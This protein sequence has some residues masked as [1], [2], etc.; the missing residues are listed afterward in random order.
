MPNT[1]YSV[2]ILA[3]QPFFWEHPTFSEF[4]HKW[5]PADLGVTWSK[6]WSCFEVAQ[7]WQNTTTVDASHDIAYFL[8]CHWV[9]SKPFLGSFSSSRAGFE[10]DSQKIHMTKREYYEK[11]GCLSEAS[12]V[13]VDGS[14][15]RCE[16]PKVEV[17][18]DRYTAGRAAWI[19]AL[20]ELFSRKDIQMM[21]RF[22][23]I[24]QDTDSLPDLHHQI[25]QF[26]DVNAAN[27]SID[28][29]D[30]ARR[31]TLEFTRRLFDR[32][33]KDEDGNI[34]AGLT[35][36]GDSVTPDFQA[37]GAA[38]HQ[39]FWKQSMKRYKDKLSARRE[40][41]E[42]LDK[43][44]KILKEG[45]YEPSESKSALLQV[46][47]A[48]G[49][50]RECN[51]DIGFTDDPKLRGPANHLA[52][53]FASKD[54]PVYDRPN[55]KE[56][57]L[58]L[59][60]TKADVLEA[61]QAFLVQFARH[62]YPDLEDDWKDVD[63][64]PMYS[65]TINPSGLEGSSPA[66]DMGVQRFAKMSNSE[67]DRLIGA[68]PAAAWNRTEGVA[69]SDEDH[70]GI[71]QH[72]C[73]TAP[74]PTTG[75]PQKLRLRWHQKVGLAA[76][77]QHLFTRDVVVPQEGDKF[78]TF[79][80][81]AALLCD[82]VGLGKTATI[83]G[84]VATLHQLFYR[85]WN[86]DTKGQVTAT[87]RPEPLPHRPTL[88]QENPYYGGLERY[89]NR[90]IV[91]VTPKAVIHQFRD[92]L[93][94]WI[95]PQTFQ[96]HI[97]MGSKQQME[98]TLTKYATSNFPPGLQVILTTD[99]AINAQAKL[100]GLER[101]E[102]SLFKSRSKN[103][104]VVNLDPDDHE[105]IY[106]FDQHRPLP[107]P[108]S[109]IRNLFDLRPALLVTDEVHEY[110][111]PKSD[112]SRLL[113]ELRL[114]SSG[115]IGL[116]AT[117]IFN[118]VL[119]AMVIAARMGIDRAI[120]LSGQ[121][122][123]HRVAKLMR[124]VEEQASGARTSVRNIQALAEDI[125]N[126]QEHLRTVIKQREEKQAAVKGTADSC[127]RAIRDQLGDAIIRRTTLN[128]TDSEGNPLS[129]LPMFQQRTH[130]VTLSDVEMHIMK[131]KGEILEEALKSDKNYQWEASTFTNKCM[132]MV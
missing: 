16:Y 64:Q 18:M 115:A 47:N 91:I 109:R 27:I 31:F 61:H 58:D 122:I 39:H 121:E 14:D 3:I 79:P 37:A 1:I 46:I 65:R 17:A 13:D 88:I 69:P 112:A 99:A 49:A 87:L 97:L 76:C 63:H 59:Q 5:T 8:N 100:A 36:R 52:S 128:S 4:I 89:P 110:R 117:P 116:T 85:H 75:V 125:P 73:H 94:R 62:Y 30:A 70:I 54:L 103:K 74:H 84:L 28:S 10:P 101:P 120:D 60:L 92:E 42:E 20:K 95:L 24:L 102:S 51:E 2:G 81:Q 123:H 53:F 111:N 56:R 126:G 21:S 40:W 132:K 9:R 6:K 72:M 50:L 71:L 113:S 86:V 108:P 130:F 96:T 124:Q 114:R 23:E 44:Y 26:L 57:E 107:E 78:T 33:Y 80:G 34:Q 106:P 90:P 127:L 105:P 7:T 93:L 131:T 19:E 68:L 83:A 25:T 48:V 129:S 98:R 66:V 43:A 55:G 119:D 67:I 22:M 29:T 104:H 45:S 12:E 15:E 82:E 32:G 38:I 118:K 35:G 11:K 77:M 41:A